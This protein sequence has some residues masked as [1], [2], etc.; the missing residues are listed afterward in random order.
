MQKHAAI[1]TLLATLLL[2]LAWTGLWRGKKRE[3]GLH[4][5]V[6]I[7]GRSLICL[8]FARHGLQQGQPL[9]SSPPHFL[10]TV[11][12]SFLNINYVFQFFSY[13]LKQMFSVFIFT[14]H[15]KNYTLDYLDSLLKRIDDFEY[16]SSYI[17]LKSRTPMNSDTAAS[18][19]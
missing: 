1:G 10:M 6:A 19:K 12:C 18:L 2:V 13:L 11:T 17:P 9:Q 8:D 15:T 14:R 7:V 4:E 3:K 16:N 5:R